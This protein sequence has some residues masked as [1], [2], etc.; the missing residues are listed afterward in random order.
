MYIIVW[1][2]FIVMILRTLTGLISTFK[3]KKIK[4]RVSH[5]IAALLNSIFVY[6]FFVY[7]FR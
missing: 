1:I 3:G 5:F 2:A 6:F 7:I 4:D